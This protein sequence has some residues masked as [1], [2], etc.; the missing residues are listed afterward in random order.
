MIRLLHRVK[1]SL[2]SSNGL[3]SLKILTRFALSGLQ[4]L[5]DTDTVHGKVSS[6]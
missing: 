5:Y 4:D 2:S 6:T 3:G 1:H